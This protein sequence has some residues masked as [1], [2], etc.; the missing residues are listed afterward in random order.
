MRTLF[1]ILVTIIST[2]VSA[3]FSQPIGSGGGSAS[4][5][6]V[7]TKHGTSRACDK[8]RMLIHENLKNVG[9]GKEGGL[10]TVNWLGCKKVRNA[11]PAE[12]AKYDNIRPGFQL[13]QMKYTFQCFLPFNYRR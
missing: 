11:T 2:S 12:V 7:D 13:V 4:A 9:K 6:S 3:G 10:K 1:L 8:A 5:W